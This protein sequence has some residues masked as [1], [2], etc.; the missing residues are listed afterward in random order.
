MLNFLRR[1][2]RGVAIVEN[3]ACILL[4]LIIIGSTAVG[5][6]AR[7][8][9]ASP[10]IWGADVGTLSLVWL[11]FLGAAFVLRQN[12]HIAASMLPEMLPE[13][14]GRALRLLCQIVVAGSVAVIGWYGVIDAIVQS[15]QT[16]TALGLPR[17]AY[18]VPIV[19]MAASM[20]LGVI[21]KAFSPAIPIVEPEVV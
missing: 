19:W 3:V 14:A 16:I 11:T 2:D 21:V 18:S 5:V 8:V 4:L 7:Y 1:I 13:T 6:F 20:M 10:L 15:G 12:G 9:L 17:S